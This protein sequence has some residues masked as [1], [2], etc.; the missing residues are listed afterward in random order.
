MLVG[1]G[2]GLPVRGTD[3]KDHDMAPWVF[4]CDRAIKL[5]G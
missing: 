1:Q 2:Y 4:V 5:H 3:N